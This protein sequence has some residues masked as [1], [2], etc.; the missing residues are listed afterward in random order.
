MIMVKD[1]RVCRRGRKKG[2]E[3][4]KLTN[5]GSRNAEWGIERR[6]R[7]RKRRLI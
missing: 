5:P 4:R 3:K 6:R 1:S 7:K 2:R